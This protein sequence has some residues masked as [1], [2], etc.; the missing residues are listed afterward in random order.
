MLKAVGKNIISKPVF[1]E[2][3]KIIITNAQRMP[4]YYEV[5]SVG[6][7]VKNIAEKD[8]ILFKHYQAEQITHQSEEF[9]VV[10]YDWITAKIC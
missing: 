5:I 2:V 9:F 7:E 3:N 1:D 4:L 6:D 8:K 10:A